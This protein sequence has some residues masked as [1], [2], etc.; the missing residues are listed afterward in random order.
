MA[1]ERYCPSHDVKAKAEP[2]AGGAVEPLERLESPRNLMGGNPYPC[3][4]DIDPDIPAGAAASDQDLVARRRILYGVAHEVPHDTLEDDLV[5]HDHGA[6]RADPKLHVPR[7]S[8]ITVFGSDAA[9]DRTERHLGELHIRGLLI[10]AHDRD[11]TIELLRDEADRA[12]ATGELR[13]RLV[14]PE[15]MLQ[16][17]VRRLENLQ[18]LAEIMSGHAEEH[19]VDILIPGELRSS[20]NPPHTVKAGRIYCVM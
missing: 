18:W 12:L 11:E 8:Q 16:P 15:M 13:L 3:V 10:E 5:A 6:S 1:E 4:A 2:V 9:Q 14:L 19:R 20:C 17:I 7:Q